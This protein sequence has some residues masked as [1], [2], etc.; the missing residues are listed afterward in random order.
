MK[1]FAVILAIGA[2][3]GFAPPASASSAATLSESSQLGNRRFV[4]TGD[5]F[6][7]VGAEDGTYP[8]TGW[9]IRGEMG[10]FWSQPIKLLDGIWFA[11]N[12]TWLKATRFTE[13]QGYT[14]M[15]LAGPG[16]LAID[17]VDVAPDGGRAGLV[18]LRLPAGAGTVRLTVD[19]HSELL[20]TYPWGGTTP[21]QTTANL[22][23]TGSFD[24]RNLVFRD[25][26][27]LTGES[28]NHSY[29]AIV[30]SNR[31]PLTGAPGA[32][33]VGV[34]VGAAGAGA[35]GAAIG[36]MA[37][38]VGTAVGA[39]IGAVAGGY[40]GKAVA[41]SVDPTAE[42]AYWRDNYRSRDYITP[43][44]EYETYQPA[45]RYGWESRSRYADRSFDEIEPEL[46]RGWN[47]ARGT[48]D[49]EWSRA[50]HAT[51]D[52]WDR[53][54]MTPAPGTPATETPRHPR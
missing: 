14:R 8:G 49:L 50:R 23:D 12:G 51:R 3:I 22:P 33:P 31:D 28:S 48:S 24:G 11:A 42:D 38:P 52:A 40:A 27:K 45:Y 15:T 35:A 30:G 4:V 32:H 17:R 6:Y 25:T 43:D 19:A 41:E 34:G 18:G 44:S 29:T 7:E 13:G 1:L 46:Q 5:R 10:G 36:S 39:V 47:S 26:G 53:L 20:S 21:S 2:V 37:G 16:G 9:H 54:G